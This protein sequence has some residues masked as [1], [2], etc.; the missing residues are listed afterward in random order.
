MF[1]A[2][3]VE[4]RST[5]EGRRFDRWRAWR[6]EPAR[7]L[8][9]ELV[10]VDSAGIRQ[11]RVERTPACTAAGAGFIVGPRDMVVPAVTLHGTLVHELLDRVRRAKTAH[12]ER[13]QVETRVAIDDPVRHHPSRA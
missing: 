11:R 5:L 13:P 3:R 9:A 1:G 8:P 6:G 4:C 10:A 2:N 12:V 7:A